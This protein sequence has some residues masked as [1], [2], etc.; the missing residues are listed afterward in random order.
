MIP[1]GCNKRP[2]TRTMAR[3]GRAEAADAQ[4]VQVGAAS[5]GGFLI[6]GGAIGFPIG[7]GK[8]QKPLG[9]VLQP[10]ANEAEPQHKTAAAIDART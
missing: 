8:G 2:T 1:Q 5:F 3:R 10:P 7:T 9:Q 6:D 4:D